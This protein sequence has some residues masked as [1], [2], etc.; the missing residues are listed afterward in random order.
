[1]ITREQV[2]N[3]TKELFEGETGKTKSA[4]KTEIESWLESIE[5]TEVEESQ[6]L[7]DLES[8]SYFHELES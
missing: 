8:Y 1:M 6:I 7:N 5:A 3:K 4:F 2:E